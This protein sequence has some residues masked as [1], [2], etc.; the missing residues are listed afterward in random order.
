MS[1]FSAIA[2]PLIGTAA[3]KFLSGGQDRAARDAIRQSAARNIA[4]PIGG[5]DAGSGR[6][7]LSAQFQDLLDDLKVN[8]QR[9]AST[10]NDPNFIQAEIDRL[11]DIAL[12]QENRT[13]DRL[14]AQQFAQGRLG[15]G[16]GGGR[17]GQLFNPQSAALEEALANADLARVGAARGEQQRLFGNLV[18]LG[19]AEQELSNNA[20]NLA[21]IGVG[22]GA[23]AGRDAGLLMQGANTRLQGG[24]GGLFQI[25]RNLDEGGFL[26]DLFGTPRSNPFVDQVRH[27]AGVTGVEF[28]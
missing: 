25:G 4:G 3:N 6:V 22:A 7:I 20:M 28:F 26:D 17:T 27:N 9:T 23:A 19:Q 13:R 18:T 21:R 1:L 5:F 16:V 11:R 15:L 8:R 10:L 12:P 2:G 24:L 14:R